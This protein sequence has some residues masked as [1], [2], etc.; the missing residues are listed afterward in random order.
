MVQSNQCSLG[1]LVRHRNTTSFT[2]TCRR[3]KT[4]TCFMCRD[5]SL[6]L[7]WFVLL[8]TLIPYYYFFTALLSS[9]MMMVFRWEIKPIRRIEIVHHATE[10]SRHAPYHRFIIER[11]TIK[12]HHAT[13]H[14]LSNSER[15]DCVTK[16]YK[17]KVF[18]LD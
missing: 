5:R 1:L 15:E 17:Y 11:N 13:C 3:P 6:S 18:L 8:Y 7:L 12:S 10:K 14:S 16:E 4:W 9:L 2:R